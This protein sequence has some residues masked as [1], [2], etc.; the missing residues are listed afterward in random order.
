MKSKLSLPD[1]EYRV[2]ARAVDAAGN[3]SSERFQI[4]TVDATP[5]RVGSFEI[6]SEGM[7]LL[8]KNGVWNAMAGVKLS[9]TLSL[10]HDTK[11]AFMRMNAM[12]ERKTM[13]VKDIPTGLWKGEFFLGEAGTSTLA[14]SATDTLGNE[15]SE[16]T[17]TTFRVAE[18]GKILYAD[19]NGL[20]K[21]LAG[22]TVSASSLASPARKKNFWSFW[23]PEASG[24]SAVSNENGEYTLLLPAGD[25]ELAVEKEGFNTAEIDP[26]VFDSP[27]F[28]HSRYYFGEKSRRAQSMGLAVRVVQIKGIKPPGQA[29]DPK[30][31]RSANPFA[32]PRGGVL[33][34]CCRRS[35]GRE[36]KTFSLRSLARQ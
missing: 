27:T 6:A 12:D 9:L 14:V 5:P 26:V 16:Q 28:Y 3:V 23:R 22:A 35:F 1:G 18:K 32:A 34:L 19:E 11:E 33:N 4:I 24:I 30:G 7:K 15:I 13:L 21:P 2:M 25:W 17:L 20:E 29:L 36:K 31:I 10:E 8:P